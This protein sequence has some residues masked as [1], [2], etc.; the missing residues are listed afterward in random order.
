[1]KFAK[2]LTT[3]LK[4]SH[5]MDH[6]FTNGYTFEVSDGEMHSAERERERRRFAQCHEF[7]FCSSLAVFV[8]CRITLRA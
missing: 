8:F 3:R 4:P 2:H 1:M 5:F 7:V 6:F